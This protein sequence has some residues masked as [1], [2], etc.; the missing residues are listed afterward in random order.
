M[1]WLRRPDRREDGGR[2]GHRTVT[3]RP[4][5]DGPDRPRADN[6]IGRRQRRQIGIP[7]CC[8][9]GAARSCQKHYRSAVTSAVSLGIYVRRGKGKYKWHRKFQLHSPVTTTRKR[10]RTAST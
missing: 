2:I 10:F 8:Q 3:D 9:I 6:K 1:A 7:R 5:H 4:G